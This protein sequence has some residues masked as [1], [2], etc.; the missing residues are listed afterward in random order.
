MRRL[1]RFREKIRGIWC[2]DW[3]DLRIEGDWTMGLMG[4][5]DGLDGLD[6]QMLWA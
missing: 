3:E 2:D 1:G 4:K 6:G 5:C